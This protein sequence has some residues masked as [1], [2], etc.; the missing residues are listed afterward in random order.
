M[1]LD[2]CGRLCKYTLFIFNLIFALVGFVFLGLGLWLRF[3][4]GTRAFF[5]IEDFN[6]STFVIAVTVLIITGLVMLIVVVFGVY[7]ACNEKRCALLTFLVLVTILAGAVIVFGVIAYSSKE[8]IGLRIAE[9]YSSIYVLYVANSDPVLAVTLTFIQK[10]LH[11]CGATG[12]P[13]LDFAKETCPD[14]DTIWEHIKMD[15]CPGV[16]VDV[17]NRNAP[18]VLGVFV[19]TGVILILV[20]PGFDPCL[21]YSDLVFLPAPCLVFVAYL[22][23]FLVLT[24]PVPDLNKLN[25]VKNWFYLSRA[26]GF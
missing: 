6:S 8:E 14:P 16:I 22:M 23:D 26:I 1:A 13:S 20:L 21:P 12:I 17:F 2:D 19:G 25:V 4:D 24:L 9:F 15:A 5:E 10:L 7:G 18:V 11:C 3:S